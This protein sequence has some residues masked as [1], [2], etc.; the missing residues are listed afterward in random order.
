MARRPKK[1][2]MVGNRVE[3]KMVRNLDTLKAYDEFRNNILPALQKKVLEGA[4][5]EEIY[6]T[7]ESYA[8]ARNITIAMTDPDTGRALSAIKDILDRTQGKAKERTEHVHKYAKLKDEELD[9]LLMSEL[10]DLEEDE[11]TKV[12]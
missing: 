8:A 12:Q 5:A 3:D 10:T 9:S 6:K 7:F 2:P 4:T 11:D 1:Q